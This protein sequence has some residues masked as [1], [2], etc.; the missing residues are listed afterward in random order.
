MRALIIAALLIAGAALCGCKHPPVA[1]SDEYPSDI[2]VIPY[3]YGGREYLIFSIPNG[4]GTHDIEVVEIRP[5]P[6]EMEER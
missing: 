2:I 3:E 6:A 4:C 1:Y 5:T